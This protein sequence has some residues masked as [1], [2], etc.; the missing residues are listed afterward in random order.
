M[1]REEAPNRRQRAVPDRGGFRQT[2]LYVIS[3]LLSLCRIA[4]QGKHHRRIRFQGPIL[5]IIAYL[6][7]RSPRLRQI[8]V[9]C[10]DQSAADLIGRGQGARALLFGG[11]DGALTQHSRADQMAVMGGRPRLSFVGERWRGERPRATH[12]LVQFAGIILEKRDR[13]QD[14][15]EHGGIDAVRLRLLN[16]CARLVEAAQSD[17]SGRQTVI[18][19]GRWIQLDSFLLR[20]Q[21]FVPPAQIPIATREYE[22]RWRVPRKYPG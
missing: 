12:L 16:R 18:V 11:G 14:I 2:L 9:Q 21:R 22:V 15:A 5:R 8:A 7:Y 13:V 4:S 6:S 17:V 20:R 1:K 3:E 19:E 10:L